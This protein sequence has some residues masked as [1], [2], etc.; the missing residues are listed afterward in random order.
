MILFFTL[1]FFLAVRVCA[2]DLVVTNTN[3]NGPGSFRAAIEGVNSANDAATIRFNIP[4]SG[5]HV[6]TPATALP[7]VTNSVTI[8]GYSQPGA[9]P[10]TLAAGDNAVILIEIITKLVLQSDASTVRGLSLQGLY[11]SGNAATGNGAIVQ[12]NFIG[13]DPT[14]TNKIPD[15]SG[16]YLNYSFEHQIGGVNPADRNLISG[17]AAAGISGFGAPN[18]LAPPLQPIR[19]EGNY[20]GTDKSGVAPLGNSGFG[21]A[22]SEPF[23]VIGGTNAGAGN[24]I[25]FNGSGGISL[26]IGNR[27]FNVKI[28]GN[29]IFSNGGPGIDGGREGP[30]ITT[31]TPGSTIVQGFFS[32]SPGQSYRIE[33]FANDECDSSGYGEGATFIGAARGVSGKDGQGS[34]S[35]SVSAPLVA[36][37]FL[38]A[39]ATPDDPSETR[40][41]FSPTS[42]FSRCVTVAPPVDLGLLVSGPTEPVA[43]LH[44]TVFQVTITNNSA[45]PASNIFVSMELPETMDFVSATAG[46]NYRFGTV[47]ALLPTLAAGAA[48]TASITVR[49]Q[50][51]GTA[52]ATFRVLA[53]QPDANADNN[54]ALVNT[55]VINA[56]PR[57]FVVSNTAASGPGSLSQAIS[58]A[59]GGAGG[60]TVTFQ[61]PGSG[62]HTIEG[63]VLP[64]TVV[65]V[66]IDGYTQTGASPNSL[67]KGD[68]AVLLID[69]GPATLEL[70]GGFSTVRGLVAAGMFIVGTSGESGGGNVIEG[71]FI[72]TD[73]SGLAANIDESSGIEIAGADDT[74]IGGPAPAARN[75]ISANRGFAA[76][77]TDAARTVIQGNYIGTDISGVVPL[78]SRNAGIYFKGVPNSGGLVGGTNNGEGNIIAFNGGPGVAVA[79]PGFGQT[80]LGNSIF[81]NGGIGIDLGT[82][83]PSVN[84]GPLTNGPSESIAAPII[85]NIIT[86]PNLTRAQGYLNGTKDGTYRVEFFS[87][88]PNTNAFYQSE[89]KSYLGFASVT[90]D[91][92]GEGRFD[93]SFSVSAQLVSATATDPEGNTSSFVTFFQP[94]TRCFQP[95]DLVIGF[96]VDG[97]IQW[98]DSQGRPIAIIFN[99]GS[100]TFPDLAS[101]A[102]GTLW[103]ADQSQG[104]LEH[105]G[106]CAQLLNPILTTDNG[107]PRAMI[108]DASGNLYVGLATLTNNVLKFDA[109]GNLA[110]QYTVSATT[111]GVTYM[112]LAADQHTL[113]YETTGGSI[114]RYDLGTR[115]QL[116]D[117]VSNLTSAAGVRILPDGGLLATDFRKVLRFGPGGNIVWS[118]SVVGVSFWLAVRLDPDRTKF[119]AVGPSAQLV[120]FDLNSGAWLETSTLDVGVTAYSL[121]VVGEPTAAAGGGLSPSL[122]ITLQGGKAICSWSSSVTGFILQ[123]SLALGSLANWQNVNTPPTLVDGHFTIANDISAAT[124]FYRLRKP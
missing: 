2:I 84:D 41:D 115:E 52:V 63:S 44:D 59:N 43:A 45:S 98:R 17:N 116:P 103:A 64:E 32:G 87:G 96:A 20:I 65:P 56:S 46:W 66:T 107:P 75:I 97:H 15:G 8:D 34:F 88:P 30:L 33:I 11:L 79:Q 58:D 61:I 49:P 50:I 21:I 91:A 23:E 38:T 69:L 89:G 14:G 86:G 94:N 22:I 55:T 35:A 42:G 60:D 93:I 99:A 5:V 78:G 105:F 106:A 24:V 13:V 111:A 81:G 121:G 114:R 124:Q 95:G 76:I 53:D 62:V 3:D 4:G 70:A 108:L 117:F 36:G 101:S 110:A 102:D 120:H 51:V 18:P 7:V 113:F 72:G 10:N 67:A 82:A 19:I 29:S 112:D 16:I 54:V 71:C 123:S 40:S 1:C 37:K 25:A 109:S 100:D 119:W 57:Q 27:S 48:V 80:I 104:R 26:S 68:N 122:N 83:R 6:I 47:T 12:G 118:N 39:T 74:R 9:S 28:A 85:T 92:A 31:A 77:Q 73:P 90:T